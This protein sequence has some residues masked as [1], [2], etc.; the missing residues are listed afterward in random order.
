MET[1]TKGPLVI[2][3]NALMLIEGNL[4]RIFSMKVGHTTFREIQNVIVGCANNNQEMV[5]LLFELLLN[6]QIPENAN[7]QIQALM[8]SL[9]MQFM[10]PVRLAKEVVERG[11]FINF[12]TSDM[13]THQDRCA[14][15]NRMTRLDGSEFL[16]MTDVRDTLHLI[17]HFVSR[18]I[19]IRQS[20]V[21]EE[22]VK[23]NQEGLDVIKELIKQ[24]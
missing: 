17:R 15:L 8:R 18:L 13:V 21:G 7:N 5:G 11:E 4:K 10:V 14:F 19:E 9:V 6:G 3:E 16:L 12:I 1:T 20:N 24:L 2:E 22:S 23:A